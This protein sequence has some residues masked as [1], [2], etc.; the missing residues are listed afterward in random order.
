[1]PLAHDSLFNS[2]VRLI[3]TQIF[4]APDAELTLVERS[5]MEILGYQLVLISTSCINAQAA[6][7]KS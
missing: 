2:D 5:N 7:C 1:M 4:S 6:H 3:R